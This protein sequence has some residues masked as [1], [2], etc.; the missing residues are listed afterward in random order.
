MVIEDKRL[1]SQFDRLQTCLAITDDPKL[2][3]YKTIKSKLIQLASNTSLS[4]YQTTRA[5]IYG[6]VHIISAP[7]NDDG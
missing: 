6:P 3:E 7:S 1:D 2:P 4:D 5:K